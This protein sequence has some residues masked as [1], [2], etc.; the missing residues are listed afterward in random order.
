MCF[1][2]SIAW[3]PAV[4][5]D[6]LN[7]QCPIPQLEGEAK[8][9]D[10]LDLAACYFLAVKLGFMGNNQLNWGKPLRY[11][12]FTSTSLVHRC[13]LRAKGVPGV[14]SPLA[15]SSS[16]RPLYLQRHVRICEN[17]SQQLNSYFHQSIKYLLIILLLVHRYCPSEGE[18]H[19]T[20]PGREVRDNGGR[21]WG[22]QEEWGHM[23]VERSGWLGDKHQSWGG[24]VFVQKTPRGQSWRPQRLGCRRECEV[25]VLKRKGTVS[26][27][28]LPWAQGCL[29][30]RESKLSVQVCIILL[31]PESHGQV[32]AISPFRCHSLPSQNRIF[33]RWS[34]EEGE[35]A[36]PSEE[37]WSL[38][39][40]ES[41]S[42]EDRFKNTVCGL[43]GGMWTGPSPIE[44]PMQY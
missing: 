14:L 18:W 42:G 39:C 41:L 25:A 28:G 33:F 21:G 5:S 1:T 12:T 23:S 32:Q 3:R 2:L 11:W 27:W 24:L 31:F 13:I 15:E 44:G 19:G 20:E 38:G 36:T 26:R 43:V 29:C 22:P 6:H 35:R 8:T 10:H 37:C 7:A 17:W 9:F 16:R 4:S 40:V 34:W 30:P